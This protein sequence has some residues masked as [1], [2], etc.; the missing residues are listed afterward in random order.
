M[1]VAPCEGGYGALVEFAPEDM[2]QPDL[3]RAMGMRLVFATHTNIFGAADVQEIDLAVS[4]ARV[5]D[6]KA[7]GFAFAV[8]VP[9]SAAPEEMWVV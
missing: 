7:S 5:G 2:P 3:A 4:F 8:V 9:A 6:T 1:K